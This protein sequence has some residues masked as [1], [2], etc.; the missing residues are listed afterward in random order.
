VRS[1]EAAHL[2]HHRA[3]TTALLRLL[4]ERQDESHPGKAIGACQSIDGMVR[5]VYAE[6]NGD[7]YV[8][9]MHGKVAGAWVLR[10]V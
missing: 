2:R 9:G 5:T 8:I 1:H 4:N 7:Q 10:R 6:P 3:P